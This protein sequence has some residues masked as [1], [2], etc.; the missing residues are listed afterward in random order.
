[1]MRGSLRSF[2]PL[3]AILGLLGGW[4]AYGWL[5]RMREGSGRVPCGSNLRQIGQACRE[6]AIEF[7]G[8]Y[9]ADLDTVYRYMASTGVEPDMF[10][11]PE[12]E[13]VAPAPPPLVYGVNTSYGYLGEGLST[14][15]ARSTV[16]LAH[17]YPAH[18]DS[19]GTYGLFA[20]GSVRYLHGEEL[21]DLIPGLAP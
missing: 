21:S 6:Y 13:G 1:M 8:L 5:E 15:S 19:D 17:C 2:L 7:D 9:P 14:G 18:H 12:H 20:D 3:V 11:C 10:I 16:P 4:L